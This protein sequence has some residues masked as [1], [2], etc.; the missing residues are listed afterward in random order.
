LSS[1]RK[2]IA[3][4][5]REPWPWK[6]RNRII[7]AGRPVIA[8]IPGTLATALEPHPAVSSALMQYPRTASFEAWGEAPQGYLLASNRHVVLNMVSKSNIFARSGPLCWWNRSTGEYIGQ[9]KGVSISQSGDRYAAIENRDIVI[10][11]APLH[12]RRFRSQNVEQELARW[13]SVYQPYNPSCEP[14]VLYWNSRPWTVSCHSRG[15]DAVDGALQNISIKTPSQKDRFTSDPTSAI[16]STESGIVVIG[17]TGGY[18]D[19][20]SLQTSKYIKR[21]STGGP[22]GISLVCLSRDGKQLLLSVKFGLRVISITEDKIAQDIALGRKTSHV[23][24]PESFK[25][26]QKIPIV[27]KAGQALLDLRNGSVRW[28]QTSREEYLGAWQA[29][30][31]VSHDATLYALGSAAGKVRIFDAETGKKVHEILA[32]TKRL[33]AEFHP[34]EPI[35]LVGRDD[36]RLL[37]F[38]TSTWKVVFDEHVAVGWFSRFQ[39]SE[40][41]KSVAIGVR[42]GRENRWFEF[43]ATSPAQ[44]QGN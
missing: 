41:G 7:P 20:V 26:D 35:L 40:D 43:S 39:W 44:H 1:D 34:T 8:T 5:L 14:A 36:G 30:R 42:N 17:N 18:S 22:M 33:S 25:R 23:E 37:I 27:C 10:R 12:T 16:K 38:D 19:V 28:L 13:G 21:I 24:L 32:Y 15:T 6:S 29:S 2:Q 11:N 4:V 31:S 3:G 9:A